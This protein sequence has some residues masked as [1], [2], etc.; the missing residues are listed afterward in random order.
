MSVR[1]VFAGVIALAFATGAGAQPA[2]VPAK[3]DPSS[4]S[5]GPLI[6]ASADHGPNSPQT[7]EA[8]PLPAKHRA[9]RVTTCRCGGDPQLEPQEDRQ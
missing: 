2:K 8:T 6:V 9:A 4:K 3:P 7:V 5:G 1:L